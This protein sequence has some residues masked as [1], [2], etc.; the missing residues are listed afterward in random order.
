TVSRPSKKSSQLE[1][2]YNALKG[3]YEALKSKLADSRKE[4]EAENARLRNDLAD[5]NEQIKDLK[6]SAKDC[7]KA[8]K[9]AK[10]SGLLRTIYFAEGSYA[11]SEHARYTI[12]E[13]ADLMK[14]N[15]D[16]TLSF[17]GSTNTNGSEEYN[18]KLSENR[19]NAVTNALKALGIPAERFTDLKW[20]GKQGMTKSGECRRVVVNFAE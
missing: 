7:D 4:Y 8:V 6:A 12:E 9:E 14:E 3:D 15:K 16:M 20:V 10:L 18:F 19:V 11:L 5:A 13:I 1:S 2:D 17:V